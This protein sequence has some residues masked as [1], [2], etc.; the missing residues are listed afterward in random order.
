MLFLFSGCSKK[1]LTDRESKKE[2]QRATAHQ[3]KKELD[4]I[5]GVY[6]GT[7]QSSGKSRDL[8]LTLQIAEVPDT[9]EGTIDPVMIPK[10]TGSLKLLFGP[11]T[12]GEFYTF[13]VTTSEFDSKSG[14]L[15]LTL[16]NEVFKDLSL[17]VLKKSEDSLVGTWVA[18]TLAANGDLTFVK[19]T[20][21]RRPPADLPLAGDYSGQVYWENEKAYQEAILTIK[22]SQDQPDRFSISANLNVIARSGAEMETMIFSLNQIDFNPFSGKFSLKSEDLDVSLNGEYVGSG[23]QGKWVSKKYGNIGKALL[24][25]DGSQ[26]PMSEYFKAATIRGVY[27]GKFKKSNPN[28]N[29]PET[30]MMNLVTVRDATEASGLK[31]SGAM[32]FYFGEIGSQD[33]IE[34]SFEHIDYNFVARTLGA[35]ADGLAIDADF[36]KDSIQGSIRDDSLGTIGS[37]V[38]SAGPPPLEPGSPISGEYKG[39]MLDRDQLTAQTVNLNLTSRFESNGQIK[40]SAGMNVTRGASGQSPDQFIYVFTECNFQAVSGALTCLSADNLLQIS[41]KLIDG[42]FTGEWKA[43]SSGKVGHII[44]SKSKQILLPSGYELAKSSSGIYKGK[45]TKDSSINIPENAM[46]TLKLVFDPSEP[47]NVKVEG[48]LRLYI[49]PFDSLEYEEFPFET[50]KVDFFKNT[51]SA[52]TKGTQ[53]FL[54][55]GEIFNDKILGELSHQTIGEIGTY[56]VN[57]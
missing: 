46:I 28:V 48:N 36:T 1:K 33:F 24:K 32:R 22:T 41:G 44:I 7:L 19:G 56:E 20:E 26:T 43:R 40:I 42:D 5:A 4:G 54:I 52:K 27:Y 38:V 3:K 2:Q 21:L 50:I 30:M 55:A 39:F 49:G 16:N 14:K 25:K 9:T 11:L 13:A 31:I 51:F 6:A 47:A 18:P 12:Q 10:L 57:K 35:P 23:F 17:T 45:I 8:L 53:I 37:F 29:L 34:Y 15:D